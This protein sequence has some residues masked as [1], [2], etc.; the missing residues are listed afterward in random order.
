[1]VKHR[2]YRH[3]L[4][5]VLV[6]LA[7]MLTASL[8]PARLTLASDAAG[9]SDERSAL[10]VAQ[11]PEAAASQQAG[12]VNIYMIALNDNGRLGKRIGCGDSVVPV[13]VAIN[14][15]QNVMRA[16]FNQLFAVTSSTYA[17]R[18]NALTRSTLSAGRITVTNGRARVE[19]FG[20]IAVNGVCDTPRVVAQIQET[21]LQFPNVRAVT[22]LVEGV[23][24]EDVLSER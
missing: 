15:T 16:A 20:S 14:P 19:L 18:H 1:M 23:P 24:I 7:L 4:R 11:H 6:A 10:A 2:P 3:G 21:A 22:V 5:L 12:R 9:S 13:R 17:G 8:A